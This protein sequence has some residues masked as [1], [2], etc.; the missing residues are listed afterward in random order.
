MISMTESY[1]AKRARWLKVRQAF[2]EALQEVSLRNVEDISILPKGL[3]QV[4]A[5]AV[6]HIKNISKAAKMLRDHPDLSSKEL[7]L[8]MNRETAEAPTQ[9]E[10]IQNKT[11]S[12]NQA[13]DISP[14]DI[15]TLADTLQAFY[16]QML[17]PTAEALAASDQAM[18]HILAV[19]ASI[20]IATKN[21]KSDF[22]VFSLYGVLD[23]YRN[24][25]VNTIK[26]NPSF[27]QAIKKTSIPWEE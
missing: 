10:V 1:A 7:V 17:R 19:V 18:V 8:A 27:Q 13:I 21:S 12:Q 2:P 15:S 23:K 5:G 6:G 16:T 24:E 20:R 4:L 3:Q 26:R 22:V 25:L 9:K 11:E 14:E